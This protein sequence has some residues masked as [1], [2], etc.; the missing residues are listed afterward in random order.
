MDTVGAIKFSILPRSSDFNPIE[1]VFNFVKSELSTQAFKQN[2]NY[3][4]FQ[5]FSARCKHT[6]ENTPSKYIDETIEPMPKRMLMVIKSKWQ[7]IK[8]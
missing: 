5:Q 3:G 8:C 6:L 1:N 4:T 2:I 7:R